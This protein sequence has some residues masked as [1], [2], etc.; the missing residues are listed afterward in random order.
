MVTTRS[1]WRAGP[2]DKTSPGRSVLRPGAY[3]F[4][5]QLTGQTSEAQSLLAKVEVE[6]DRIGKTLCSVAEAALPWLQMRHPRRDT[7]G[8]EVGRT[9]S[10]TL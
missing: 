3:P 1:T 6:L 10:Q 7:H 8:T 9:I 4:R 5:R 2:V